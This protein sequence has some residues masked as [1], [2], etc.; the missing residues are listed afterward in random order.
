MTALAEPVLVHSYTARGAARELLSRR[1]DEVL[2]SGP[3][4]T[5]KSRACLEKLNIAAVK[6]PRMRGLIVRQ[7]HD[8]LQASALAT[9]EEFVIPEALAAGQ[10]VFRG[11]TARKPARYE[12][13]NGSEIWTSG[14]DKP[15]KIMSTEFDSIYVMEATELTS[16]GWESLTTRLGRR[17]KMPYSQVIADCNPDAPSHWLKKRVDNGQCTMLHSRH[18]DNPHFFDEHGAITPQGA[19]YLAKLD[20]LTGVRRLRLR[21][22][23]WV[24][25]EGVIWGSFDPARH[26]IDRFDIPQD[27]I[28][29]WTVDFGTVH[30]FVLQCWAIDGD[31][32][33]FRYRE[34]H[35]TGRM[36]EDH[37]KQIMSIVCP[38]AEWNDKARTWRGGTWIEPKPQKILCD[39]DAEDRLTLKRYLG[40]GNHAA[41]KRV[42]LGL[43]ATEARWRDDRLFLL[44]DSLVERDAD[45]ADALLPTSTEEE[46]GGYVWDD[47]KEQ[48]V[49]EHDDGCDAT[50]YFVA[51]RDLRPQGSPYRSFEY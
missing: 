26:V 12:Y 36:V 31:G 14:M 28:R 3:V 4:G 21:D 11:P 15:G 39:H 32:R 37:A 33:G 25:A 9:F 34:I 35:M 19:A 51:D 47:R 5:G 6:Y 40:M 16:T 18:K 42:K 20:R 2:L 45:A 29:I 41:D 38:G 46:I 44:R 13:P 7:V 49:K 24:A 43:D 48:P 10:V 22:G 27:W 30:P 8:R 23:L 50:R 17:N 1:D